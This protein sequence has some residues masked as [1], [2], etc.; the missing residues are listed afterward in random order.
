MTCDADL[1]DWLETLPCGI[2]INGDRD[3]PPK[4]T[5]RQAPGYL[6]AFIEE[7]RKERE[8]RADTKGAT[9]DRS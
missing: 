3:N 2:T 9:N 6:R 8:Q 4:L 1:L 7:A 5:T